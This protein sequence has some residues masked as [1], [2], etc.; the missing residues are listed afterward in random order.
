MPGTYNLSAFEKRVATVL[1]GVYM[2]RMFGLFLILPVLFPAA[3]SLHGATPML[4]G[5]ALG[6]YGLSQAILQFPLGVWSD[7]IGRKPV[8]IGGLA[9][10]ALGSL[11][12]GLS[13]TIY[14]VVVGRILQGCGAVAA[15]IMAFAADLTREKQ[16]SRVNAFLGGG[17]GVAFMAALI[18][19][20]MLEAALGL[21]GVFFISAV[22]AVCAMLLLGVALPEPKVKR[23]PP[24]TLRDTC[25]SFVQA[26]KNVELL[27]LDIGVFTLHLVLISNFLV[28]PS[29]LESELGLPGA[30]HWMFYAPILAGSFLL[31]FPLLTVAERRRKIRR[32]ILLMV[33]FLGCSQWMLFS[34]DTT[35]AVIVISMLL[36][37]VA[38]NYLEASLPSLVGRI[39][40]PDA[41]GA[42]LGVFSQSQ[43]LGAFVGGVTSGAVLEHWGWQ[44]VYLVNVLV[45]AIWLVSSWAMVP[46]RTN[47]T[48]A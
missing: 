24:A 31:M 3:L 2:A 44:A 13:D 43:F 20:P 36:F 26:L 33:T 1:S 37:F 9:I 16:R 27:R 41:R 29:L 12:A 21:S 14:G 5:L 19:A 17:I 35:A 46:P 8:I 42:S 28:L 22:C 6:I 18:A 48:V 25:L 7:R 38:F 40:A 15:T 47:G 10:F 23:R 45:I 30:S 32:F 11:V 4:I 39:C 34:V